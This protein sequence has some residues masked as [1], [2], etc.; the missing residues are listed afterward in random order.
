MPLDI[1]SPQVAKQVEGRLG[2]VEE[3]NGKKG[4]MMS[5]SLCKLRWPY[6]SRSPFEEEGLSLGRMES[7]I[8]WILNTRD[9]LFSAI[10]VGY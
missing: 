7:V 8:R 9:F 3:L 2:E 6:E 5:I 1:I 10:I 4:R